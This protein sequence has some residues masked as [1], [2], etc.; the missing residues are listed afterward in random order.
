MGGHRTHCDVFSTWFHLSEAYDSKYTSMLFSTWKQNNV[1]PLIYNVFFSQFKQFPF[2]LCDVH[3]FPLTPL[4]IESAQ[5]SSTN[6]RLGHRLQWSEGRKNIHNDQ[7][8][9]LMNMFM[10]PYSI[11]KDQWVTLECTAVSGIMWVWIHYTVLNVCWVSQANFL[12]SFT[13]QFPMLPK[14]LISYRMGLVY[15]VHYILWCEWQDWRP[16]LISVNM[17][18]LHTIRF[19]AQLWYLRTCL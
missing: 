15:G 5:Q 1:C 11:T 10:P 19:C 6:T 4:D 12:L 14:S 9:V 16:P 18:F 17:Y 13:P 7:W 3:P 8:G 2:S